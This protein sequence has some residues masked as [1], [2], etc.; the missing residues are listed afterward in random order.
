VVQPGR[1]ADARLGGG[2]DW[3]RLESWLTVSK[4][5][6]RGQRAR[7][8]A[9]SPVVDM[10]SSCHSRVSR[11]GGCKILILGDFLSRQGI[12]GPPVWRPIPA[13]GVRVR[14]ALGRP[15]LGSRGGQGCAS[16]AR[17]RCGGLCAGAGRGPPTGL[18]P[19]PAPIA[20]G[21]ATRP[22]SPCQAGGTMGRWVGPSAGVR[23]QS[24][25]QSLPPVV[26]P[27][28][29]PPPWLPPNQWL[30]PLRVGRGPAPTLTAA[31]ALVYRELIWCHI[32]RAEC[33]PLARP[34]VASG[35]QVARAV[36]QL[37]RLQR[38]LRPG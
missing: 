14:G 8:V 31:T 7:L 20:T 35:T 19:G 3:A 15:P 16:G 13:R 34:A 24:R 18:E 32:S 37:Q 17:V 11:L 23:V 1:S 22:Q 33:A 27:S 12:C 2:L 6:G 28:G 10:W 4:R 30:C 29:C 25:R 36:T 21:G 26:A 38:Q 9:A 5:E